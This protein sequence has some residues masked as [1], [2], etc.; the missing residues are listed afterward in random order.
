MGIKWLTT[1]LV[2]ATVFCAPAYSS[3]KDSSPC[4]D[5]NVTIINNTG[6]I[7][8]VRDFD[9]YRDNSRLIGIAIG[10]EIEQGITSKGQMYS[11]DGTFGGAGGTLTL[12]SA[13]SP[14]AD[15]ELKFQCYK[16]AQFAWISPP[17]GSAD[18]P[19]FVNAYLKGST[20]TFE[21]YGP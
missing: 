20:S 6:S 4:D 12:N 19:Y 9:P 18:T 3:N 14:E 17:R 1:A 7:L 21:I 15:I 2:A 5:L 11:G 16:A 10:T 13:H 8:K